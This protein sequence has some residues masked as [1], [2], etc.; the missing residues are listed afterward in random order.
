ME[1]AVGKGVTARCSEW[2][3]EL[4]RGDEGIEKEAH[5]KRP[6]PSSLSQA[7]PAPGAAVSERF[8]YGITKTLDRSGSRTNAA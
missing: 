7:G 6:T 1:E 3:R 8:F 5:K 2:R 4:T